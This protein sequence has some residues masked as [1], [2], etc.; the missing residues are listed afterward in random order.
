MTFQDVANMDPTLWMPFSPISAH[1]LCLSPTSDLTFH[2]SQDGVPHFPVGMT[3]SSQNA[4][5]HR[6][7]I[8]ILS[9]PPKQQQIESGSP[10]TDPGSASY[11][12]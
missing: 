8:C 12:L 1:E 3:V 4:P 2:P 10:Q 9:S 5:E 11:Q 6:P 7:C